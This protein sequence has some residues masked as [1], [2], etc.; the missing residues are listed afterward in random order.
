MLSI[1][2]YLLVV[3]FLYAE[4]IIKTVF[5]AKYIGS[6]GILKIVSLA[7]P[8]IFNMPSIIITAIDRQKYNTLFTFIGV[9]INVVGNFVLIYFFKAEGAA[10]SL[11]ITYWVIFIL[12]T[13]YLFKSRFISVA[14]GSLVYLF[15]IVISIITIFTK[16][17]LFVEMQWLFSILLTTFVYLFLVILI[18]V[19]KDDVRI[20]KE[21]LGLK[22]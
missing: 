13:L 22:K 6:V 20:I 18:I 14:Y 12:C 16:L 4:E 8:P 9:L 7:I 3:L 5:T 1:S 11:V 10:I 15:I 17:Y 2:F 19:K 21:T